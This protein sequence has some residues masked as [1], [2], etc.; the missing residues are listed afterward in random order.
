MTESRQMGGQE[1][2]IGSDGGQT[3][4]RHL[5]RD[6]A[7]RVVGS[8]S[9]SA[10]TERKKASGYTWSS[11]YGAL[12]YGTTV[13]LGQVYKNVLL[14]QKSAGLL[15]RTSNDDERKFGVIIC[16]VITA[17][18]RWRNMIVPVPPHMSSVCAEEIMKLGRSAFITLN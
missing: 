14:A 12:G 1:A 8:T 2:R 7:H 10:N 6:P 16:P 17:E 13:L 11:G 9:S 18:K 5:G 3:K 15:V 4:R